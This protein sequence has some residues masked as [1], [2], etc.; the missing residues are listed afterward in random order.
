MRGTRGIS[1]MMGTKGIRGGR[2]TRVIIGSGGTQTETRGISCCTR[3]G[4]WHLVIVI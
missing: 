3:P 2:G 4:I 1:G